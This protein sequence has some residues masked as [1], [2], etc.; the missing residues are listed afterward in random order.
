MIR[1]I[2]RII[3]EAYDKATELLTKH[4]KDLDVIADALME[5]ETLDGAHIVELMDT[6]SMTN[7]PK[8]PKPP[9]VPD[10]KPKATAA[11]AD[12]SSKDDDEPLAG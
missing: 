10:D 3:D 7:P 9:E 4:R 5:F 8:S 6:G 12:S 11:K 1:E 2:K